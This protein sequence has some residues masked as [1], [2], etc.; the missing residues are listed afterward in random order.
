M[1]LRTRRWN[2]PEQDGDGLR[3]LV[4][5]YRPRALPKADETWDVWWPELGPSRELHAAFHGKGGQEPIGWAGFRRR[6]LAEKGARRERLA[7][8]RARLARGE[9]VTLLCSSA[10]GDES[11]CHRG[12]LRAELER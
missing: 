5:R 10:C 6:Y 11:R 2:D 7:E 3:I 8:I 9:T 1:P 12:L 4:C